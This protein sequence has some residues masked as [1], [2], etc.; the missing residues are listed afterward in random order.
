M[1]T[2]GRWK[3]RSIPRRKWRWGIT[4]GGGKSND[5]RGAESEGWDHDPPAKEKLVPLGVLVL[6]TGRTDAGLRFRGDE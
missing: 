2:R 1:T 4:C 3:S 5:R 6:L